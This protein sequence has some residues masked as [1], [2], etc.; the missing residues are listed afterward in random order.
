MPP[1]QPADAAARVPGGARRVCAG[2]H[3]LLRHGIPPRRC[4]S[5]GATGGDDRIY[6]F[7]HGSIGELLFR[8]PVVRE[9]G[10]LPDH[11]P[12]LRSPVGCLRLARTHRAHASRRPGRRTHAVRRATGRPS[13]PGSLPQQRPV[14]RTHGD[15]R[16]RHGPGIRDTATH[17]VRQISPEPQTIPASNVPAA[18]IKAIK[19]HD[20]DDHDLELLWFRRTRG[21]PAGIRPATG[22]SSTSTTPRS[23]S[24]TPRRAWRST[25]TNSA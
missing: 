5:R 4:G 17:Q 6:R 2:L 14:V 8:R 16:Q 21:R 7:R 12:P 19:F 1:D 20:P 18:G 24:A 11:R 9:G 15:R 10:G 13:H 22:S 3:R 23:P 25:A